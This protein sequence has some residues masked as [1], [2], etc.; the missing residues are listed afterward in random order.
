MTLQWTGKEIKIMAA[1]HSVTVGILL[2]QAKVVLVLPFTTQ[3]LMSLLFVHFLHDSVLS[4]LK[5]KQLCS[6]LLR[7]QLLLC[8]R[9]IDKTAQEI[10]SAPKNWQERGRERRTV[11]SGERPRPHWRLRRFNDACL[12]AIP[13][14]PLRPRRRRQSATRRARSTRAQKKSKSWDLVKWGY[15]S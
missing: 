11:P 15:I 3:I 1:F 12:P 10:V 13:P 7:Y 4:K 2:R 9:I 6:R 5:I 14:R 8:C